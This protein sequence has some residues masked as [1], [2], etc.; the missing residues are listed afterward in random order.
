[1]SSDRTRKEAEASRASSWTYTTL[2]LEIAGIVR[3]MEER[4]GW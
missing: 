1:V 2:G 3:Y 4:L